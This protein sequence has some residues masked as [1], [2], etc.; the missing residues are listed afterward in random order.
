MSVRETLKRRNEDLQRDLEKIVELVDRARIVPELEPYRGVLRARTRQLLAASRQNLDWLETAQD[1]LLPDVLS[2][3]S[4]LVQYVRL[5][6]SRYLRGLYRTMDWDR[7]C[8]QTIAWLHA[9]HSQTTS[10]PAVFADDDVSIIPSMRLPFYFFPCVEQ[11]GLRFQPLFFHEFGHLLYKCHENELDALVGEFQQTVES[12]LLPASQRNDQYAQEQASVRQ[13][14]VETWYKWMQ[15][16]FCD[17]VGLVI[18]GPSFLHSF[19]EYINKFQLSDYYRQPSDLRAS[20][21][22]ISN[23]RITLLVE[24]AQA[25][26]F[27]VD[28]Q[29]ISKQWNESARLLNLT[30]DY[31]G[32]YTASLKPALIQTLDDMLVEVSPRECTKDDADGIGWDSEPRN[33]VALLNQ[34]WLKY[35]QHPSE[36]AEWETSVLEGL[37]GLRSTQ[38]NSAC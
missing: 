32:F 31:H 10:Y 36:F 2:E 14:I 20:T 11:R 9:E 4:T 8:L 25:T 3:T 12:E 1:S 23:L 6:K 33:L 22:P 15:E 5:L 7:V 13:S 21:H 24:R 29:R 18:G 28:A 34:V 27:D 19:S 17:A 38:G 26:G 16:F 35:F 30:E 37:Y